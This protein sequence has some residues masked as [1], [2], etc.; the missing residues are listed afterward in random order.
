VRPLETFLLNAEQAAMLGA[1]GRTAEGAG[2]WYTLPRGRHVVLAACAPEEEAK[3]LFLGG[4]QRGAFSYYLLETLQRARTPLSYRDLFKRVN[5]LVRANT[6]LQSPQMETT[7]RDDLNQPF[8]GGTIQPTPTYYSVH[9]VPRMGWMIDGGAVHGIPA[10]VGTEAAVLALFPFDST[11][12]V[13]NDLSGAIGEARVTAAHPAQSSVVVTLSDEQEPDPQQTY[14][15]IL[16]ALPLPPL[17][18][19]LTGD[20]TALERVR[21]ALAQAAPNQGPSLFV[22]EGEL[23]QGELILHAE[24]ELYRIRRKGDGYPLVVETPALLP[25]SAQLVVQRLEHIAR[26]R[27]IV[28]LANPGSRLD[29]DDIRL[30]IE[31]PNSE[32]GWQPAAEGEA[33]RHTYR[34]EE[35]AWHEP[36][37]RVKLS[38]HSRRRLHCMLFDLTEAYGIY[39]LLPGGGV[40]LG[41]GEETWANAGEPY[42]AAVPDDLWQ[43]GVVEFVDTL[44]VIASTDE[45]DATQL[46]QE[47][48]PVTIATTRS[49]R[50]G[51]AHMSTLNRLL[52][53]V[54]TRDIRARPSRD[55]AFADWTTTE[56]SFTTVRPQEA[57][58]I[59][60]EGEHDRL[61]D[62]VT[63][64]GH[65]TLRA[66]ARLTTLPDVG[67]DVGN[68]SLPAIL[69]THSEVA[70][71]FEFSSGRSGQPGLSVLE[72]IDVQDAAVVTP[73][74][75]LVV[76]IQADLKPHE[77]LLAL[78]HDGEFFLPVGRVTRTTSGVTVE[79]VRLP[80]P[81]GTRSLGGSIKIMFQKLLGPYLG[82]TYTY[83]Q[84]AVATV[85]TQGT[86]NYVH[87]V[88][89]VRQA[90]GHVAPGG[91][92]LL[93]I[94][95]IIGN[96]AA[97]V[98]GSK[99]TSDAQVTSGIG[100]Q[101]QLI[102]TFD[103]E[104]LHTK[105]EE[106][107]QLLKA[108]LE[109]V[110]LGQNHGRIVH[111]VAHSM[112][113][114]VA[115]WL[116]EREGGNQIVQRL[117]MVG[118][119]NAGS[120][121]PTV[122]DWATVA[123]GFGLNSVS[124]VAWPVQT[125]SLLVA[126]LE[127]VDVTLDQMRPGSEILTSLASSND[128]GI[129]YTVIIGN[130][131]LIPAM[132]QPEP[133]Q[134]TSGFERLWA[135]IK[136]KQWLYH[137]TA[138][139]FFGQPNDIAV[140]VE[141]SKSLPTSAKTVLLPQEV[142]CD[143]MSY[144]S[145]VAGL[146]ALQH[147]FAQPVD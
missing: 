47:D 55:E 95:G 38:N 129:P 131:S 98:L 54:Q 5:A 6:A 138:S 66:R 105:I 48:L 109:A 50:Q 81:T 33:I 93:Y 30:E 139:V 100:D 59:P 62:S 104:N 37:F 79:L 23:E 146:E 28:D 125:L 140:A 29:E 60:A 20:A 64:L 92:I 25:N 39:A 72:L 78:A 99:S 65:P 34:F 16:V 117:V 91:K 32:G 18:V 111:I 40:W 17:I 21:A 12:E 119:P 137:M 85:T 31:V 144:F 15:A 10:P 8:L 88:A 123:L 102:L 11:L 51:I 53:R 49:F 41:P 73:E 121:W 128:P 63:L 134:N 122:Q 107:A 44:L 76:Q 127:K 114:L 9:H 130:T 82:L 108:R 70:Q 89:Q 133:G 116:V 24:A 22:R 84:L 86:V 132:F 4:E 112:G 103:Y 143:H 52:R 96:T 43:A 135:R 94:H 74:T 2:G 1:T 67:R 77:S 13:L 7:Q 147:A 75:P 35:G 68:M 110:G 14:K 3:E 141:S 26:W 46:E 19:A 27:K 69:R 142:A 115:R 57:T 145:T 56:V 136:P 126:A 118:T 97:M 45:G 120:P 42:Y 106:N 101:Y 90:V 58:L 113:G 87:D 124:A 71:P 83:P 61:G 36:S 80:P